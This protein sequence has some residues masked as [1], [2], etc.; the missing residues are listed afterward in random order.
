MRN[1]HDVGASVVV[2][3]CEALEALMDACSAHR[4]H[5]EPQAATASP[6][7]KKTH[8][9]TLEETVLLLWVPAWGREGWEAECENRE[10]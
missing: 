6:P 3:E 4:A 10:R 9:H 8:T 7:P 2:G 5:T 1:G